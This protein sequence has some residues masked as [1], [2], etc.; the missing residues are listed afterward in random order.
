MLACHTSGNMVKTL[1]DSVAFLFS[2]TPSAYSF[3]LFCFPCRLLVGAPREKAFP[4]QQANR[5]GGLYSC[6]IASP[7]TNCVRVK[8]DEESKFFGAFVLTCKLSD[9]SCLPFS[10]AVYQT[11]ASRDLY[12]TTFCIRVSC[13]LIAKAV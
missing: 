9:S 10:V 2:N 6:D 12:I 13:S 7:N 4:A 3:K 8:F 5:T 11:V 1:P